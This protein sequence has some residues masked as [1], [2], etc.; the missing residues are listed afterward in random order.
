MVG[1]DEVKEQVLSLEM[2][3]QIVSKLET[4]NLRLRDEDAWNTSIVDSG[5]V[6]SAPIK[7]FVDFIGYVM[8]PE[9]SSCLIEIIDKHVLE[10]ESFF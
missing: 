3:N 5:L 1:R 6:V 2:L 8:V 7:S 9:V 4:L 10:V